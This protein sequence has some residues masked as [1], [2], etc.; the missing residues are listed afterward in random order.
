[1]PYRIR[2][3]V[4]VETPNDD[5]NY[6]AHAATLVGHYHVYRTVRGCEWHGFGQWDDWAPCD[7][8]EDGKAKA[9]A[10]Y[11][12]RLLAALEPAIDRPE[13]S[14]LPCLAPEGK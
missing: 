11:R 4:W 14:P 7:S 10:H 12:E 3:L 9:E 1:M 13:D 5:E 8:I 2:P 6:M